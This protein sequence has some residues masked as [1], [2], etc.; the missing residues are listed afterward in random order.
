M[1]RYQGLQ[2]KD[3]SVLF[4][5]PPAFP[6]RSTNSTCSLR[7][8]VTSS[9]SP[10]S[11]KNSRFFHTQ[12]GMKSTYKGMKTHFYQGKSYF[13]PSKRISS[14]VSFFSCLVFLFHNLYFCFIPQVS[15]SYYCYS[16]PKHHFHTLACIFIPSP[17]RGRFHTQTIQF[18]TS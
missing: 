3:F 9:Q 17:F 4:A 1:K 10:T 5:Y 18:H 6:D 12:K 13:I 14:L 2:D 8:H 15:F 11:G 7:C 16:Y